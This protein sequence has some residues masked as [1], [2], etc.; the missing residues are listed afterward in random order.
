MA[1]TK[2]QN[3]Y[4]YVPGQRNEKPVGESLTV[5]DQSY[6]IKDILEKYTRGIAP[7]VSKEPLY[8]ENPDINSPDILDNAI[9]ITEVQEAYNATTERI[10]NAKKAKAGKDK[11]QAID[12]PKNEAGEVSDQPEGQGANESAEDGGGK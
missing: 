4:N 8:E 5:P 3:Q 1:K 6:S 9:D 12:P 2:F 11:S 10:V 7:M